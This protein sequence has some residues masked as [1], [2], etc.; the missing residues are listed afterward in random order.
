M[1]E[2]KKE[3]A[4]NCEKEKEKE[5]A[6]A[7]EEPECD[8]SPRPRTQRRGTGAP[9]LSP[10]EALAKWMKLHEDCEQNYIALSARLL[11]DSMHF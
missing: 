11:L 10:V 7:K 6:E 9:L 4:G 2:G 5:K 3:G 8:D 1:S